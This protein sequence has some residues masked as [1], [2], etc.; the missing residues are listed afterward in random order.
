MVALMLKLEITGRPQVRQEVL[1]LCPDLL[2]PGRGRGD[3]GRECPRGVRSSTRIV[4]RPGKY[5]VL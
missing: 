3:V 5:P 2:R 4:S 1:G